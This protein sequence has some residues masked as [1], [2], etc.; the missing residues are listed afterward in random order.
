[1]Q[2]LVDLIKTKGVAIQKI[3]AELEWRAANSQ[4]IDDRKSLVAAISMGRPDIVD[5]LLAYDAVVDSQL[6][7]Q[8]LQHVIDKST[9]LR[10]KASL[11]FYR[12]LQNLSLEKDWQFGRTLFLIEMQA[13][14][15]KK[16]KRLPNAV[17]LM[18]RT[19]VG[20][21][22]FANALV[23]VEYLEDDEDFETVLRVAE[24]SLE[25]RTATSDLAKSETTLPVVLESGDSDGT[26]YVDL[27]GFDDTRGEPWIVAAAQSMRFLQRVFAKASAITL[28]FLESDLTDPR[29]I[30]IVSYLNKIGSIID[31][32]KDLMDNLVVVFNKASDRL[33]EKGSEKVLAHLRTL[34][35]QDGINLTRSGRFVLESMTPD[36]MM[37][38][39]APIGDEVEVLKSKLCSKQAKPIAHYNFSHYE[40][41]VER[42]GVVLKHIMQYRSSIAAALQRLHIIQARKQLDQSRAVLENFAA[43]AVAIPPE[44]ASG[45]TNSSE[46]QI[47]STHH[48]VYTQLLETIERLDAQI[49]SYGFVESTGNIDDEYE[50]LMCKLRLVEQKITDV[51]ALLGRDIR[52]EATSTVRLLTR[53]SSILSVPK[54]STESEVDVMPNL[55][56]R[57]V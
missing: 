44:V 25:E 19:G 12:D 13:N 6:C 27:P 8:A 56:H 29:K 55:K 31:S 18:G 3:L 33:I 36:H 21:S 51:N 37:L 24:H 14:L 35:Q 41:A 32:R 47:I 5:A 42:F 11:D 57:T 45:T 50:L 10:I 52:E 9:R 2:T 20:K 39:R 54:A 16:Y 15:L 7:Q 22:T 43:T 46:L 40:G 48:R 26:Y 4:S 28:F 23:G 17:F 34:L 49:E 30:N 1:M 53:Y 38:I